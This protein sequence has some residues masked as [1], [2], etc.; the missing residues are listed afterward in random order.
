MRPVEFRLIA[1]TGH[2][3][4]TRGVKKRLVLL[5]GISLFG[6]AVAGKASAADLTLY[7]NFSEVRDPVQLSGNRF[8]WTPASDLAGFI[9]PGSLALEYDGVANLTVLP[10]SQNLLAAFEG[11]EVLVKRDG[12]TIK[13]KVLRADL[14]LFEANGSY[15]QGD[16]TSVTFPSL[17]GVRFAPQYIWGITGSGGSSTLS[18][19]TRGLS[20]G[21]RYSLVIEKDKADLNGWAEIRNQSGLEYR[22]PAVSLVAGQVN[23]ESNYNPQANFE[24]APISRASA[25]DSLQATGEASGLQTF[26]YAQPVILPP[27]A[28]TSVPFGN[29]K[30]SL[31]RTLEYVSGFNQSARIVTPLSRAYTLKADGDLPGGIVT[32]REDGRVVGQSRIG[33]TPKAEGA[34]L[35]LGPDFDLRLTRIVQALERTKTS[36]K[37]RVTY[38]LT[39][40]KTRSVN[41]RLKEILGNEFTLTAIVLPNLKR[42]EDGFSASATLNP[43]T[44]LEASYNVSLK[45]QP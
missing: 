16:V 5:A 12:Q 17:D 32:V 7:Y 2:N 10:A 19:L 13:A 14:G 6:S 38:S 42:S 22:A 36:Q 26:K 3:P 43:G 33:D 18:Y 44:R 34:Q 35:A 24:N 27:R 23:L 1:L 4:Y 29:T 25:A 28:S 15:F 9:V 37:F 30:V 41:V 8:T 21:P 40:T 45:I 11:K 39:N 31:D 20:W